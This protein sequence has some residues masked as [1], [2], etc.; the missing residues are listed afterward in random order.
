MTL[1]S[2]ARD[3]KVAPN[4]KVVRTYMSSILLLEDNAQLLD[5]LREVVELAGHVVSTAR[6][7][8]EGLAA[9]EAGAEPPDVIICDLTMPEVDGLTFLQHVRAHPVWKGV[10]CIAMS[11]GKDE[12]DRALEAGADEYIVKPFSIVELSRIL[13]RRNTKTE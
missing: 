11:G 3:P 6:N 9:I 1:V 4:L 2:A 12:R 10:Y 7:G 8:L 13:G 5:V